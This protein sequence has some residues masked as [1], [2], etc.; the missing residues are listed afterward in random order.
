MGTSLTAEFWERFAFLLVAAV[1]LTVIL[2]ATLDHVAGRLLS[3]R[4]HGATTP[5]DARAA[6]RSPHRR[7]RWNTRARAQHGPNVPDERQEAPR[8]DHPRVSR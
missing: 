8:A 4:T 7:A 5:R 1:A 2:T 3:R 6:V